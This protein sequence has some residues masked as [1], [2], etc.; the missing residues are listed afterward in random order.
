MGSALC[1]GLEPWGSAYTIPKLALTLPLSFPSLLNTGLQKSHP[2]RKA[3][4][5]TKRG[6][7]SKPA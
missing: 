5:N 2:D 1:P 3:P 6:K 4:V 7:L